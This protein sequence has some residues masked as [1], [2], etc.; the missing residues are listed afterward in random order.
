MEWCPNG[1][2]IGDFMTK[3]TRGALF[4]KFRDLIMGVVQTQSTGPGK[5]K[6]KKVDA[7]ARLDSRR[8]APQECVGGSRISSYDLILSFRNSPELRS[9]LLQNNLVERVKQST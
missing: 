8:A 3:P 7:P 5:V 4:K 2:M 1:D 9:S 6:V